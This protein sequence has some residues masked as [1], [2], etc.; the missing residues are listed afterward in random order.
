[1]QCE[2]DDEHP[3]PHEH[4][5]YGWNISARI[6]EPTM[7]TA[8]KI[9]V[10]V[11][12]NMDAFEGAFAQLETIKTWRTSLVPNW[13]TAISAVVIAVHTLTT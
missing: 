5:P 10:D 1:M 12:P 2:L 9:E 13:I 7:A 3:L 6:K 11:V 4:G 8:G